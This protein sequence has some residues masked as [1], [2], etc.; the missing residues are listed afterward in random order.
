[1][2]FFSIILLLNVSG[3]TAMEMVQNMIV[4]VQ[5]E[6]K[7]ADVEFLNADRFRG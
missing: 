7:L 6:E 3:L 1:M 4:L 2:Y 5:N